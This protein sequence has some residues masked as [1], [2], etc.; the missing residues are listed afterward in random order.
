M[1]LED[2]LQYRTEV[3]AVIGVQTPAGHVSIVHVQLRQEID[4]PVAMV[5]KLLALDLPRA[6]VASARLVRE[7]ECW[8]SHLNR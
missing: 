8:V 1:T 7:P 3:L 5:L 2:L 6:S 4:G